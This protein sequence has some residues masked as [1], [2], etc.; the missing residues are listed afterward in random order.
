MCEV[1]VHGCDDCV[2]EKVKAKI[3]VDGLAKKIFE[4]HAYDRMSFKQYRL[5]RVHFFK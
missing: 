1:M 5:H 3:L 4:C 2:C